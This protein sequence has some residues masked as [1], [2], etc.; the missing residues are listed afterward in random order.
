MCI[1][2]R[3]LLVAAVRSPLAASVRLG[4]VAGIAVL[5]VGCVV[6]F[7]MISNNS[8]IFQ[9]TFGSGF[10]NRTAA[11]L[12][13][14][15][16]TIGPEFLLIRPATDGGDLVL[17]H[18]IGV[19]GLVLLAVPAALLHRTG[20][21]ARRQVQVVGTA[22]AAVVTALVILLVHAGRQL[23]LDQLG[24]ATLSALGLCGIALG[25]V[26]ASIGRSLIGRPDAV[27]H[28]TGSTG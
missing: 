18:A 20:M 1:R 4:T 3:V 13:P 5:L 10:T 22:V 24:P 21:T 11:Y 26:Y 19:H 12:G 9:G 6:G 28:G 7:V 17:P 14:D 25:A 16:S 8:G 15:G 2:D 27:D 23:P